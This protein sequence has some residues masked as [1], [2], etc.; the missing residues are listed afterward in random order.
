MNLIIVMVNQDIITAGHI[1]SGSI[2]VV[3]D[4]GNIVTKGIV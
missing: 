3:I 2:I 1:C 4:Y